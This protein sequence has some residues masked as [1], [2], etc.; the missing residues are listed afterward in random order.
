[1]QPAASPAR[2]AVRPIPNGDDKVI[3]LKST[4]IQSFLLYRFFTSKSE[5]C[6]R[7]FPTPKI[8]NVDYQSPKNSKNQ[9]GSLKYFSNIHSYCKTKIQNQAY[10]KFTH[11]P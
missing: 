9:G 11:I 4:V 8:D 1:M 6:R 5:S 7:D 3:K 2:G 10:D